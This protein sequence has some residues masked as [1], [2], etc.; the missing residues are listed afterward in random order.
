MFSGPYSSLTAANQLPNRSNSV[1][2]GNT[3]FNP[4]GSNFKCSREL[5]SHTP[6][7]PFKHHG[8]G[9]ISLVAAAQASH[10][11]GNHTH[12]FT[13]ISR[14]CDN[15]VRFKIGEILYEVDKDLIPDHCISGTY[16]HS[17]IR[18]D[19]IYDHIN[20]INKIIL[21]KNDEGDHYSLIVNRNFGS[22][23]AT[24]DLVEHGKILY[25]K[26]NKEIY[27][28]NLLN[29]KQSDDTGNAT[30]TVYRYRYRYRYNNTKLSE[31]KG[32]FIDGKMTDDTGN[33]TFTWYDDDGTKR[34]YKGKFMDGKKLD[35]IG[36]ATWTWYNDDGTRDEYKG[37]FIHDEMLDDTGNATYTRY[38][39][40]GSKRDEYKGEFIYNE[41]SDG[42]GN[43]TFTWY[44]ADGTKR[45]YKG[46]FIGGERSDGTGNA[47][48]T[49]YNTDGSKREEYKGKFIG[50]ER[51]DDTGNATY[52]WY[53]ADG[54]KREEY[55]GKFI[56][57]KLVELTYKSINYEQFKFFISSLSKTP[58]LI[59]EKLQDSISDAII[60]FKD[61][62]TT[63]NDELLTSIFDLI[64]FSEPPVQRK[65]L[66]IKEISNYAA[67]RMI[68]IA[69]GEVFTSEITKPENLFGKFLGPK[70]VDPLNEENHKLEIN[71]CNVIWCI[72]QPL[73]GS[74]GVIHGVDGT[75]YLLVYDSDYG[76]SH[77][78]STTSSR[79]N[80]APNS[81][82]LN[83][84]FNEANE[85]F[86]GVFSANPEN[87]Y[88]YVSYF[89]K[90]K[91]YKIIINSYPVPQDLTQV[92]LG[93]KNYPIALRN[94]IARYNPNIDDFKFKDVIKPV[95]SFIDEQDKF[96]QEDVLHLKECILRVFDGGGFYPGT[97]GLKLSKKFNDLL[98]LEIT[99]EN[100]E[101]N[102]VKHFSV[103][104]NGATLD[105]KIRL[106]YLF[107]TLASSHGLGF[108]H[109]RAEDSHQN[110]SNKMFYSLATNYLRKLEKYYVTSQSQVTNIITRILSNCDKGLCAGSS[111]LL[112]A[113]NF[114]TVL[115][116]FWDKMSHLHV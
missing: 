47:T 71:G 66:A 106:V 27:R 102:Y 89:N 25:F 88:L 22:T 6:Y 52:T 112:L 45:K 29:G 53:N 64:I 24:I 87:S 18:F 37:K 3:T 93:F 92:S 82:E 104:W 19:A 57:G 26:N 115:G 77:S 23:E 51:S 85:Q 49:W 1:A 84:I 5:K 80:L 48:Y 61:S 11:L 43:A 50:G 10:N 113:N 72:S 13:L 74:Y 96:S 91:L 63:F 16:P 42:T 35:D 12:S 28:G 31:Y 4:S 114:P 62:L 78:N 20:S 54:S 8:D 111:S 41:R 33:A 14:P 110:E 36:N 32:K 38:N 34:K 109:G 79:I 56:G 7:S 39:L 75:E 107:L 55:K 40:D 100:A 30:Y 90:L 73:T 94:I 97:L 59:G 44:N 105:N 58:N 70:D 98:P 15:A 99:N 2:R 9:Y 86:L 67:R 95:F 46:K 103:F 21:K 83:R 76:V 108:G 69:H 116:D 68:I 65:L 17:T 101:P 81:T 60:H